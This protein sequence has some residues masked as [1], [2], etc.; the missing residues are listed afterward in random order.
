MKES[1]G[2]KE[3]VTTK[4]ND[5]LSAKETRNAGRKKREKEIERGVPSRELL[6]GIARRPFEPHLPPDALLQQ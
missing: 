6:I 3:T 1:E 5:V 2:V 4:D